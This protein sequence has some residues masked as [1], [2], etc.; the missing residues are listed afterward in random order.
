[1]LDGPVLVGDVVSLEYEVH[2]DLAAGSDVSTVEK[3]R[4]E[5]RPR[6]RLPLR[7]S[8]RGICGAEG[9]RSRTEVCCKRI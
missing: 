4:R 7:K 5:G 3:D 1:L 8:S 2:H 6:R 9:K